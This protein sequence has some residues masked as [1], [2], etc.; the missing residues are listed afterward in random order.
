MAIDHPRHDELAGRIDH[1]DIA[2]TRGYGRRPANRRNPIICNADD[3]VLYD[4]SMD[5]IEDGTADNVQESHR[6]LLACS[7]CVALH[8]RLPTASGWPR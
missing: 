3:T 6:H 8:P 2:T 4:L 5:R 7:P 1:V